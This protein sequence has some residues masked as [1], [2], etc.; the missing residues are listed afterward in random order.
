MTT[1]QNIQALEILD[2]RGNP[3]VWA[4]ITL[5]DGHKASAS[6][7]S[8]ASTGEHEAHELRDNDSSRY[9]GKGVLK[10]CQN[11]NTEIRKLLIGQDPSDQVK[12]DND[13]IS[14]DGTENKSR[15][16]AN[17]ILAASIA[18]A[19][20]GAHMT[21]NPLYSYLTDQDK[22]ELSCPMM[23]I[24][25]GGAHA[26]NSLDFQEFMIRPVSAPSMKESIRFGCEIFHQLKTLLKSRGH[27]T[28]VGDEGGFAPN[29]NSNEEA[30]DIILEAIEKAGL[31]P[32]KDIS[33]ALDCA[34][35]EFYDK[36][37][38]KYIEKKK[39][40]KQQNFAS[41]SSEEQVD[42]LA[43]LCKQYPIDSIED[44]LDENDWEGWRVLTKILGDKIQLVGDDLFVTNPKFLEKGI[45]QEVANAILI[46]PNQIGSVTETL[47]TIK[48]AQKHNYQTVISHRSGETED[49]FI[50][51][52][53][54]A[55]SAGQIKTGSLSRSDRC[56]KYNRL[57][58]IENQLQQQAIFNPKSFI[59]AT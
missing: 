4:E 33:L 19:K 17:A 3:T 20:A 30:F 43:S 48:L 45:N 50:A 36:S 31:T 8:G 11:I 46:K 57:I 38:G 1:I 23:N 44:A 25:N 51:D 56:S 15:L 12:I 28:A 2:S 5:S 41:R 40:I 16:G 24:I 54:V 34:A 53:A 35:S 9:L 29:L 22:F 26:N 52:L 27:I 13:L 14:L 47:N 6:V 32:G 59:N 42:Y 18:C 49:N 39:K 55:T 7:P 37:S 10:A 21:K 58:V